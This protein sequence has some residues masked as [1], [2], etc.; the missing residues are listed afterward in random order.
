MS[1]IIYDKIIYGPV[2]SRRLGISLGVNLA[3]V[4]GKYCTFNCIY[5]ECGLNEEHRPKS[6]LPTR[7]EVSAALTEK[8]DEMREN[9]LEGEETY[10]SE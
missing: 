3:P 2:H 9:S 6:P 4:D 1:T 7:Q 10:E 8:L 5:C